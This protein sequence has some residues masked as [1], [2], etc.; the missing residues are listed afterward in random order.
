MA[1]SDNEA[2]TLKPKL[3]FIQE[4]ESD[5]RLINLSVYLFHLYYNYLM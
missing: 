4:K 3:I 5:I 1:L 2:I